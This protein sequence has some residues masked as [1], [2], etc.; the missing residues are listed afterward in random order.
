MLN[1]SKTIEQ[2]GTEAVRQLR[3]HKLQNGHPFMITSRDLPPRQC[4][5][6]YPDGKIVLVAL[7][8]NSRDFEII[9]VLTENESAKL[10]KK[11]NLPIF[12]L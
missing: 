2:S 8:I 12:S 3:W 11:N 6:E 1:D 7:P 10:R 9:R 5:L 4:Y